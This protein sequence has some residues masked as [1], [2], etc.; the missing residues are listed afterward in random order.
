MAAILSISIR[1]LGELISTLFLVRAVMSWFVNPASNNT[2]VNMIYSLTEPFVAP[3][4][5]LMFKLTKGQTMFD[6]SL[7]IAWILMDSVIIPT[8]IRLVNY[9]F[10]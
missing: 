10:I 3:I 7:V 1:F 5:N 4:R 9:I 2:F 8:L 6:F